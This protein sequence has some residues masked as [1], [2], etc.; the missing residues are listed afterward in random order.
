MTLRFHFTFGEL[1]GSWGHSST[2]KENHSQGQRPCLP[3]HQTQD[4][5]SSVTTDRDTPERTGEDQLVGWISR[6]PHSP[7]G[8]KHV[9]IT[10]VRKCLKT[11]PR[12]S[13]ERS[14]TVQLR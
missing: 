10:G 7:Q 4:P 1:G 5:A 12:L 3:F 8:I 11:S 13:G 2:S 6:E 9:F 14:R